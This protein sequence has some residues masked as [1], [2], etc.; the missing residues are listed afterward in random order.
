MSKLDR[1]TKLTSFQV[2]VLV[3]LPSFSSVSYMS[4]GKL[5]EAAGA[6][7]WIT[8]IA[9]SFLAS[10]SVFIII[11]LAKRFPNDTVFTFSKKIFGGFFG[12]ILNLIYIIYSM[13]FTAFVLRVFLTIIY[14]I[15][16]RETP[17]LLIIVL[18]LATAVYISTKNVVVISRVAEISFIFIVLIITIIPL[19]EY[20]INMDY[21]LPIGSSGIGNILKAVIPYL[22]TFLGLYSLLL[23]IPYIK[24]KKASM[25]SALA[26]VVFVTLVYTVYSIIL[27]GFFGAERASMFFWPLLKYI[28]T[29][30]SP[31]VERIDV[32]IMILWAGIGLVSV[33]IGFYFSKIGLVETFGLK[34]DKKNYLIIAVVFIISV[35]LTQFPKNYCDLLIYSKIL[36]LF[37]IGVNF[38]FPL[39]LLIFSLLLKRR[40]IV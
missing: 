16:F 17:M 28:S 27:I 19:L 2:F 18:Y 32:I 38:I 34:G 13:V 1:N 29:I 20:Q 15:A 7:A 30:S 24:N 6:D 25:K 5:I 4:G 26:G 9:T 10:F 21:L 23:F 40:E 3:V 31:V 12:T 8:C 36:V 37:S 33:Y 11:S 14:T 35:Y 39:I 22:T